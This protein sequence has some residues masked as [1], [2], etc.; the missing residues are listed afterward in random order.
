MVIVVLELVGLAVFS[1]SGALA[2]V[3][4]RLDLFGVVVLGLTTALGG[5][6]I[7]DVLLGITPP[8]TLR[9]WPYLAVPIATALGVFAF[10]P[11]VARLRKAVLL[12]DAVGLGLFTVSGTATALAAGVPAYTACLIG[13][14]SGIGGGAMRDL[15]LREI[16]L[17]LRREIYAVAALAGAVVVVAGARLGLPSVLVTAVGATL[18]VVIRLVALWR[19][20]NAPVAPGLT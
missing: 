1:A 13:M 17:V 12:L 20:W 5:G 3:R 14:T 16:P 4:A 11:Q 7:R 8:T 6:I 2:A 9:A 15:L 19:R 18:V 10:H